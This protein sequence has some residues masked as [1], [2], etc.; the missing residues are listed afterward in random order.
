MKTQR[1]L[2]LGVLLFVIPILVAAQGTYR[3]LSFQGMEQSA[4]RSARTVA[5]GGT[6]I[7]LANDAAAL[8]SNP[9]ALMQ[10]Q[11]PEVRL[12]ATLYSS[13]ASV[14]VS[15]ESWP[16]GSTNRIAEVMVCIISQ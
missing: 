3:P 2:L 7:A 14:A 13:A 10:L 5:M 8:F 9:A 4:I 12:G 11:M 1:A 16:S 15:L 6:S